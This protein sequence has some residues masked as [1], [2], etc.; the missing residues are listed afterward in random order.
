MGVPR[1][2]ARSEGGHVAVIG[3]YGDQIENKPVAS[4]KPRSL[5]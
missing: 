5:R 1:R 2:P 3:E 4:G